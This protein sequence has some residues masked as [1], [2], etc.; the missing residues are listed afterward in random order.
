MKKIIVTLFLVFT[1][2]FVFGCQPS[3]NGTTKK[4]ALSFYNGEELIET[5]ELAEGAAIELIEA[6]EVGGYKFVGWFDS[7]DKAFEL[8][9]MPAE[10]V[11]VYA[12]Y[13]KDEPETPLYT[14]KFV[15]YDGTVLYERKVAEGTNILVPATPKREK[16]GVIAYTFDGWVDENG[17]KVTFPLS[18]GAQDVVYTAT[19]TS[20]EVVVVKYEIDGGNWSYYGYAD[21][22]KD[23]LNDYNK[24]AGTSYTVDSLPTGAWVCTN[25]H[26]FYYNGSNAL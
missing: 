18:I 1:M 25:F 10:A 9:K 11:N 12:K 24:F 6:P 26:S 3:Q 22:V 17:A 4:Y 2:S 19:Y 8:T 14:Y 20:R 23:L 21:V 5:I 7:E 15:D 16:E 13:E